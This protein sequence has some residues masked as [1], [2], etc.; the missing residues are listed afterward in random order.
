LSLFSVSTKTLKTQGA[1]YKIVFVFFLTMGRSS[2][3]AC[4][5]PHDH[6]LLGAVGLG[7]LPSG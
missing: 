6:L 5:A 7:D 3:E 1:F 4:C 2:V